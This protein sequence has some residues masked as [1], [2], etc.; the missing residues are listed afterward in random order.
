[1]AGPVPAIHVFLAVYSSDVDARHK[2]GHD[3]LRGKALSRWLL[4]ESDSNE[5]RDAPSRRAEITLPAFGDFRASPRSIRD[6]WDYRALR[7]PLKD[8]SDVGLHLRHRGRISG[9]MLQEALLEQT[10]QDRVK[11]RRRQWLR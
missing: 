3:E 1:M 5:A 4:F 7:Y 8:Q 9:Q 6:C 10:V 11:Y 2:A